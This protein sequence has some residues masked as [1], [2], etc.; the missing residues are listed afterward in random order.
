MNILSDMD[1]VDPTDVVERSRQT[2]A[3]LET[4]EGKRIGLLENRKDNANLLLKRVGDQ[5]R[6][7]YG[8]VTTDVKQKFIF[9][10][11][12]DPHI[13]DDLASRCDAVVTAI[14]D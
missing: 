14:A 12:A 10:M 6:D 11:V 8:A 1:L 3:P 5:L 13:L 9:S 2:V 4:M 7:H